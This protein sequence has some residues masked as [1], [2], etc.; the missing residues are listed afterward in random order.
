MRLFFL[1]QLQ[2][3]VMIAILA[4]A[5]LLITPAAYAQPPRTAPGSNLQPYIDRVVD[6]I[7]E[8]TLDNGM[9]FIVMERHQAPI[10]SFMTYVNI[11]AAYE[12]QGKTFGVQ[13][14][15]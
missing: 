10:V 3:R 1:P 13:R 9:K 2:R 5:L 12:A 7:S 11:G 15:F 14:D 6:R 4:I 8:F